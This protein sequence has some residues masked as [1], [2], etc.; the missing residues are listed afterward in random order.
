MH[1]RA[2]LLSTQG[3]TVTLPYCFLNTEVRGVVV[4]HWSRW[5]AARTVHHSL[6]SRQHSARNSIST[7]GYYACT[8]ETEASRRES[9]QRLAGSHCPAHLVT[10]V[11]RSPAIPAI[12][13]ARTPPRPA[14]APRSCPLTPA[15]QKRSSSVTVLRPGC[16]AVPDLLLRPH[17]PPLSTS[18]PAV[19]QPPAKSH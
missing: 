1:S 7:A 10:S 5:R 17:P 6:H 2:V 8:G 9:L 19:N 16:G 11:L 3:F 18:C 13:E 15:V 4:H 12:Q 14:P